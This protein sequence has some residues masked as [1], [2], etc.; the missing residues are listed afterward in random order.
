M[1]LKTLSCPNCRGTI[2]SFDAASNRGVCPNCRT[3][4]SWSSIAQNTGA[5]PVDEILAFSE[6]R[7][8]DA[9]LEKARVLELLGVPDKAIATLYEMSEQYPE[10]KRAWRALY[11]RLGLLRSM[12]E[13][14]L[15]KYLTLA[16]SNNDRAFLNEVL[17][18]IDQHIKVL[19]IEIKRIKTRFSDKSVFSDSAS[20]SRM[21]NE[22]LRQWVSVYEL[23][24]KV[25]NRGLS[26]GCGCGL[27]IVILIS[28]M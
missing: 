7:S 13:R 17:L 8:A 19:T 27:T 6:A 24:S 18:E 22:A 16:Y 20:A 14:I 21:I 1:V 26:L 9:L 15:D 4:V 11:E 10:D 28:T 2:D 12:S 25:K 5:F 3:V 23:E